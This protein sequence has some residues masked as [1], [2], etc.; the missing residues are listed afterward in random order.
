[1]PR[2]DIILS[3][4]GFSITKVSGYNPL[5]IDV[6]YRRIHCNGKNLRKKD[7]F[8]RLIRH[9][10]VGFRQ[11]LLRLKA[12]KFYCRDCQRYFN[13]QFPG[14]NKHQRATQRLHH[15]IFHRHTEGASQKS[16]A[17]DFKIG[18]ATI[19][20]W[21]HKKYQRAHSEIETKH[22]LPILG[23]DEHFFSRKQGYA[24]T[25]C[26]LKKHKIFDIVKGR[27]TSELRRYL[28]QLPGK[29]REGYLHRFKQ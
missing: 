19:E 29:K 4:P 16:L 22:C 3:L 24:T 27:S 21:Y 10:P 15:H 9:E 1:M 11:N 25:F 28:K 8:M 6:N 20:R 5:V 26:N 17:R 14:V 13:L 2:K 18:K 7:S 23:I 12:H